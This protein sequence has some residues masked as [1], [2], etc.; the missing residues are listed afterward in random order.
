MRDWH[1]DIKRELESLKI[2]PAREVEI[3]DELSQHLQDVYDEARA[4]G[5]TEAEA[6]RA[7]LDELAGGEAFVK[8]FSRV[9]LAGPERVVLGASKKSPLADL[10]YDLRYAARALRK[11]PG[12]TAVAVLSL[13][14][15]IGAN[16]A[17]FQVLDA[18]LMRALPVASPQELVEVRVPDLD[19]ARGSFNAWNPTVT[20]PIW[21]R[22]KQDQQAFSSVFAWGAATFNIAQT[23]E[24][25]DA[26]A[27]WV[28]GDF[29]GGL[30]VRPVLGRVI[31]EA[32]DVR[33]AQPVAVISYAFWQREFGGSP[34]VLGR[35]ISL[36][37]HPAE[38]VGVAPPSFFGLEVGRSFDVAVPIGSEPALLGKDS[39]L[40][41]GTTWWL[42]MVGRL[43]PDWTLDEA[44]AHVKA[45]SPALFEAT[46]SPTYPAV[47]VDDYL[48]M[49]LTAIPA[50]T[51]ISE[52]RENF[53]TPLWMLLAI[54]GLVLLIACANLANLLLARASV[55]ERE[56]AVRLALGASRGRLVRQ[57]MTENILL[58]ACGA[59]AGMVLAYQLSQT[60]VSFLSTEDNPLRVDLGLDWRVLGFTSGLA[61]AT[62]ILFG[63]APA[64]TA[65]HADPGSVMRASGRGL[66]AK[67]GRFGLRRMLVVTQVAI[68][69]VL[70]VAAFLFTRSLVNLTQVETGFRQSGI[71]IASVDSS[72]VGVP[73]EAL[74]MY[75]QRLIERI[76]AV[77][78]VDA[79][80]TAAI[81]PLSGGAWGNTMWMDGSDRDHGKGVARN[82]VGPEFFKTL[83]TPV[84]AGREFDERDTVTSPRV[85]IVNE[86]FARRMTDG[87]N[88]V[89]LRFWIEVTPSEPETPYEIVGLVRDAKYQSL[90][91]DLLPVAFFPAAQSPRPGPFDRFVIRS[92]GPSEHVLAAIRSALMEIDPRITFTFGVFETEIRDSL[93]QDRLVAT[94]A[95][96]FGVLA[97]VLSIVGL[98]GVVSYSAARRTHVARRRPARHRGPRHARG[99]NDAARGPRDRHGARA[100]D[101]PRREQPALRPRAARPRVARRRRARPRVRCGRREPDPGPQGGAPRSDGRAQGG[102]TER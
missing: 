21:E 77:P 32:D 8:G 68:S 54:A 1:D 53:G 9:R 22:F 98:Y 2:D 42:T 64:L 84:L 72:A 36:D 61:V 86:E 79:A 45:L 96:F 92:D 90:R 97:A 58:A 10:W 13:A 67:S 44:D 59:A 95:G 14:L 38:I 62:C 5:A 17:I 74:T 4:Q 40:D 83:E 52:L 11:S 23:G 39:Q 20:N 33:G 73:K 82:R 87:E 66:T 16:T 102:V 76:G 88:P 93:V 47:S 56:I 101:G 7:A 12:F 35:S 85:A 18:V 37:G 6:R 80:T 71:L 70:M 46:L 78:G 69:L 26:R 30:G 100:R 15:G 94:L 50:G 55:R 29:F 41:S 49:K 65:S 28:S 48:A 24:T 99:R 31:S 75:K 3:V 63:L 91:E 19:K 51:G 43:K 34:T 89:G 81:V 25:R 57:L 60:L 27:L